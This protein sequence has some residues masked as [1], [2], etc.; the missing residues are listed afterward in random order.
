MP[1]KT[2]S[3]DGISRSAPAQLNRAM[4]PTTSPG[5]ANQQLRENKSPAD[6]S[7]S[8]TKSQVK[9]SKIVRAPVIPILITLIIMVLL[10]GLAYFAYNKSK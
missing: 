10:I 9:T 5:P 7:K 3:V 1:P 6:C 4:P 2:S 8:E